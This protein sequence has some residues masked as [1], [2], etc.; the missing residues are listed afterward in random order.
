VNYYKRG[1]ITREA[2]LVEKSNYYKRWPRRQFELIEDSLSARPG[3]D[4]TVAITFR[5][6]FEVSNDKD[7]RSGI[8]FAT[9]GIARID[10]RFV[11]M[12]EDGGVERRN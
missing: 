6:E 4:D 1:T 2:V 5:Y 8:G 7:A 10:G 11:I 12:S 3:P 9:L